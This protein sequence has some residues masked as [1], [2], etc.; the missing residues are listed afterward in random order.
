M[1]SIVS[2]EVFSLF[3]DYIRGVV[4]AKNINNAG[5]NQQLIKLLREVEQ[6]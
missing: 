5:E 2:K 4:I 6:K 3:P 1:K